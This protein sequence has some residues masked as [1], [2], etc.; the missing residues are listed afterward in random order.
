MNP[1]VTDLRGIGIQLSKLEKIAPFNSTLKNFLKQ[2]SKV[3]KSNENID[4]K[5]EESL[6]TK[7][8]LNPYL[9]DLGEGTSTGKGKIKSKCFG[10]SLNVDT[11]NTC[12]NNC[13]IDASCLLNFKQV[14][15]N[16][17]IE[18]LGT[19]KLNTF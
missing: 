19:V 15:I 4:E 1:C 2:P 7:S 9:L 8:K 18:I 16:N 11:L 5:S 17:L 10:N 13:T 14:C 6:K 3:K 12:N